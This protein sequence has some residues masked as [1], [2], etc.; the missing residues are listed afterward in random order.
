MILQC[1]RPFEQL[2]EA[3]NVSHKST[4]HWYVSRMSLMIRITCFPLASMAPVWTLTQGSAPIRRRRNKMAFHYRISSSVAVLMTPI[5]VFKQVKPE[6]VCE[7]SRKQNKKPAGGWER[8]C[9]VSFL[10]RIAMLWLAAVR[11]LNKLHNT[12]VIDAVTTPTVLCSEWPHSCCS[13]RILI[14]TNGVTLAV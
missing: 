4:C 10:S 7:N 2:Q 8:V 11:P 14:W 3:T 12:Y 1:A 13:I 9:V 5:S 6:S